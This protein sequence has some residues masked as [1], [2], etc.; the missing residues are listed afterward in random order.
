MRRS[1]AKL[2]AA[3]LVLG[4]V[5]AA[6]GS[7]SK[8]TA[9]GSTPTT[10]GASALPPVV[11]TAFILDLT[12]AAAF[13]G[14]AA[15]EGADYAVSD[16]AAKGFLGSTKIEI[17]YNDAGSDKQK[18]IDAMTK[19][20]NSDDVAMFGPIF[21][22]ETVATTPI[23]QQKGILDITVQSG[24]PG[25][26]ETGDFIYRM[27]PPQSST[28]HK[29]AEKAAKDGAKSAALIYDGSNPT[30]S[31]LGKNAFPTAFGKLNVKVADSEA[32][33]ATDTDFAAIATKVVAA[34]PDIVGIL[35]TGSKN[36]T[37]ITQL[38]QLGYNGPLFGQQGMGNQVLKPVSA[39]AEGAFWSTT[40]TVDATAASTK[41]FTQGF[42]AKMG[43]DPTNF[44][45]EAFDAVW[46]FARGLKAAGKV[47]R[48]AVRD[49]V[50]GVTKQ[51]IDGALGHVTF[52]N[53]DARIDGVLVAWKGGKET[54]AG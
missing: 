49:G 27:T 7:S 54:L 13:A 25:V 52:E 37:I 21:S 47:D 16:I 31:D 19:I 20:A 33:Q 2:C 22:Q 24:V 35:A 40:Y 12:G 29:T 28:V 36:T 1:M 45:A 14:T 43:H 26:V 39:Q 18:A 30:I 15:K 4:L 34:K 41:E 51:G 38:R 53:R 9:S 48:T 11:K 6:C 10:G 50:A 42:T 32:F 5:A 17:D 23:A 8:K 44:Q 3:V 46:L